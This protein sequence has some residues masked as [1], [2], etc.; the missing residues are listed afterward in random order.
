MVI[1][2]FV[3]DILL[4]TN[5]LGL[6][7]YIKNKLFSQFSMKDLGPIQKCFG[8]NIVRDRFKKTITLDQASYIISILKNFS[9]DECT[10]QATSMEEGTN[11]ILTK[12]EGIDEKYPFRSLIGALM[13]LYQ[14]SRPDISFALNVLSRFSN[15]YKK[16]HWEAAKRI[17][18]YLKGTT[19][20]KITYGPKLSDIVGYSD[21][22]HPNYH[23]MIQVQ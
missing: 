2:V 10:P 21:A 16:E 13:Y 17:L 18:K 8:F 7:K 3:D 4:F 6:L 11:A 14:G 9:M 15:C 1:T 12:T 19:N 23:C 5:N 22:G 20:Y